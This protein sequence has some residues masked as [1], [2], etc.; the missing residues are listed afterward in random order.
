MVASS[1]SKKMGFGKRQLERANSK[2]ATIQWSGLVLVG[3]GAS[4]RDQLGDRG[5]DGA[6]CQQQSVAASV[7]RVGNAAGARDS[8]RRV[9]FQET[10]L[11]RVARVRR[12]ATRVVVVS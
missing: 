1:E 4:C 3:V 11:I 2:S 12:G 8:Y 7:R 10:Q 6:E 9:G 5:D